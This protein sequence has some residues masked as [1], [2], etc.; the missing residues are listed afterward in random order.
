MSKISKA[1]F[2]KGKNKI[3]FKKIENILKTFR[4][5]LVLNMKSLNSINYLTNMC[6]SYPWIA[7]P[8]GPFWKDGFEKVEHIIDSAEASTAES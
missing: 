7:L 1:T 3:V 5:I 4:N 8:V 2:I 6:W